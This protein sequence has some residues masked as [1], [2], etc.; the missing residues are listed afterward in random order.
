[1]RTELVH[2]HSAT[3]YH[4]GLVVR[5]HILF[6]GQTVLPRKDA[7]FKDIQPLWWQLP[8]QVWKEYTKADIVVIWTLSLHV[9]WCSPRGRSQVWTGIWEVHTCP[10]KQL[11]HRYIYTDTD[12]GR[13]RHRRTC[14]NVVTYRKDRASNIWVKRTSIWWSRRNVTYVLMIDHPVHHDTYL[15]TVTM[16]E[17]D[18]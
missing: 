18:K 17:E 14:D 2:S 13:H 6:Y 1:M 15:C 8:S 4:S 12:I 9:K 3:Y 11:V 10:A 7:D 16:G 5:I